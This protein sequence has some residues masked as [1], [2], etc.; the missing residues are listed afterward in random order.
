VYALLLGI[1]KS[2]AVTLKSVRPK[3]GSEIYLLGYNRPL[4][5]TQQGEDVQIELPAALA[6]EYA[7][8][9]RFVDGG[10]E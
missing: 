6:G 5:W 7:S 9:L 10:K 2:S 4:A 8:A 3:K 1:P